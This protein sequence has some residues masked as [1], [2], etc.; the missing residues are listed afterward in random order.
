MNTWS[1]PVHPS[2]RACPLARRG[3]RST[4]QRVVER[5]KVITAAGV[6]AG[7]DMALLARRHGPN[8]PRWSSS[9]SSTGPIFPSM[10]AHRR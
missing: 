3:A 4:G 6:S 9:A 2:V 10:R 1:A 7:I 8:S 5:G